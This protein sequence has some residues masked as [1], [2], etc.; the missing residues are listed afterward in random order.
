MGQVFSFTSWMIS[1]LDE[2]GRER[3]QGTLELC[4]LDQPFPFS[5]F[6]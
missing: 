1:D 2:L 6:S 3:M 4:R 5:M